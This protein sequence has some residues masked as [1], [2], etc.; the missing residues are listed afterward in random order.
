MRAATALLAAPAVE[1]RAA[2]RLA[3]FAAAAAAAPSPAAGPLAELQ[4]ALARLWRLPWENGRKEVFWRLVYDAL[5]TA[6]HMHRDEPCLC[7]ASGPRPDR[8]HHFWACPV[9]CAVVAAVHAALTAA[10]P[11]DAPPPPL[12]PADIWL[13]RPPPGVRAGAWGVVCLAAVEAMDRGRRCLAAEV[14][15]RRGAPP[16]QPAGPRFTQ[17]TLDGFL[18]QPASQPAAG[19]ASS[20]GGTQDPPPPLLEPAA[21]AGPAAPQPAATP[22]EAARR[23]ALHSFWSLLADFEALGCS[24]ASWVDN[25]GPTHP[26]FSL[27]AAA[28]SSAP[29][30]FLPLLDRQSAPLTLPRLS[31][32]C[33]LLTPYLVSVFPLAHLLPACPVPAALLPRCSPAVPACIWLP[34]RCRLLPGCGAPWLAIAPCEVC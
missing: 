27:P 22:L 18:H 33:A 13:A 3:P 8:H 6:A 17:L 31:P 14:L 5:P 28:F 16:A 21:P 30:L 7:G 1:H 9:A 29:L 20:G 32:D 24:P 12:V 11:A 26:F 15:R 34:V 4:S 10:A 2:T 19:A 23:V 25:L